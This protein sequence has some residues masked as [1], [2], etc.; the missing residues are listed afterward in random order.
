MGDLR[1]GEPSNRQI[2]GRSRE[3]EA[4]QQGNPEAGS[5][6]FASSSGGDAPIEN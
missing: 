6:E 4:Q 3:T 2:T 1:F 5:F